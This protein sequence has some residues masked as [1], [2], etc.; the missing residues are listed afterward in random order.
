MYANCRR[1]DPHPELRIPKPPNSPIRSPEIRSL[2]RAKE[3]R[4][5]KEKKRFQKTCCYLLPRTEE[6]DPKTFLL[7][8]DDTKSQRELAQETGRNKD[9]SSPGTTD[10]NLCSHQHPPSISTT[11]TPP[12]TTTPFSIYSNR[13]PGGSTDDTNHP[14]PSHHHGSTTTDA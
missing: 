1:F 2:F 13:T 10:R 7:A 9:T 12:T 3:A 6:S 5:S 11:A 4:S 8:H 14:T